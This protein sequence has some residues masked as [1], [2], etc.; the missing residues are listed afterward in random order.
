MKITNFRRVVAG[1][2]GTLFALAPVPYMINQATITASAADISGSID[3][4][5]DDIEDQLYYYTELYAQA[6]I[7]QQA[8]YKSYLIALAAWRSSVAFVNNLSGYLS[9]NETY[10]AG[11]TLFGWYKYRDELHTGT[12]F[13]YAPDAD[14][15]LWL[16]SSGSLVLYSS[17]LC[18]ITG[19]FESDSSSA[20]LDGYCTSSITSG[21]ISN[22]IRKV[23][24]VSYFYFTSFTSSGL[25]ESLSGVEWRSARVRLPS[26][27][28]VDFPL[29]SDML[30]YVSGNIA[31][32]YLIGSLDGQSYDYSVHVP[33]LPTNDLS[34]ISQGIY[35]TLVVDYPKIT[36]I[37]FEPDAPAPD[38]EYPTDF[39]T[40]IPKEWTIEN[41]VLPTA[42]ALEFD[43]YEQ[44]L[45][46][47]QPVNTLKSIS[48][49]VRGINFWWWLTEKTL[50]D[51]SLKVFYIIFLSL[52]V[53][54]F[55]IWYLGQ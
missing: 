30:Q 50:D 39:V 33:T 21:M 55:V 49:V 37:W 51:L 10:P 25:L 11:D 20:E 19:N 38:P 7:D 13:M 44:D 14:G 17:D 1:V 47:L 2:L 48:D 16:P 34:A 43:N 5:F 29:T 9:E 6:D 26:S 18:T 24:N 54:C 42:P 52:A 41:P 28:T 36:E 31:N 8:E 23:D 15:R 40:G 22:R 46:E 45:S 4:W 35:N 3:A 12:I 27:G 32:Y 53:L